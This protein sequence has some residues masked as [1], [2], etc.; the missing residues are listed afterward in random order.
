MSTGNWTVLTTTEA[1][2][3]APLFF[4]S[5]RTTF[6]VDNL[7]NTYVCNNGRLLFGPLVDSNVILGT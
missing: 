7:T 6:V 1:V 2:S 5:D 4:D 3:R